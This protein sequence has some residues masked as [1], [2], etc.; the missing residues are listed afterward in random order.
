MKTVVNNGTCNDYLDRCQL[1]HPEDVENIQKQLLE[2]LGFTLSK[3][4][5][6]NKGL[7]LAKLLD[8]FVRLRVIGDEYLEL[9]KVICQDPIMRENLPEFLIYL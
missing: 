5:H 2:T 1:D 7:R 8:L 4:H 6:E 3:S 9:Y